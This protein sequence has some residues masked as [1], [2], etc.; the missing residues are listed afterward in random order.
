MKIIAVK[1]EYLNKIWPYIMRW[2]QEPLTHEH[3]ALTPE[4]IYKSL[5][6]EDW[7]LLIA[8]HNNKIIA[9]QTCEIVEA[10]HRVLNLVTTGGIKLELWQD[11]MIAALTAIAKQ[12]HCKS[13]LTRG[14]IGWLKQLKRNGFKPLYFIAEKRVEQCQEA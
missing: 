13:I 7:V 9:A 8:N 4:E 3:G 14:R 11:E 12:H 10:R 1:P 2:I 5:H 6:N